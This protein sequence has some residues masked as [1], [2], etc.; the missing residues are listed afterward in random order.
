MAN[1]EV[2]VTD[3]YPLLNLLPNYQTPPRP[4]PPQ[5]PHAPKKQSRRR[6]ESDLD[7]VQS[8]SP[9]SPT[10]CPWT[11]LTTHSTVTVQ[12][13]TQDGTSVVVTLRL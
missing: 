4:I 2:P 7:S 3:L 5:Q 8:Q 1:R 12:A 6:L 13:T 9:L 10:E 11:I